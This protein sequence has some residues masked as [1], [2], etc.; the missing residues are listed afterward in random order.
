MNEVLDEAFEF[1]RDHPRNVSREDWLDFCRK[2]NIQ[3]NE[4]KVVKEILIN[5]LNNNNSIS[6]D[7]KCKKLQRIFSCDPFDQE[8]VKNLLDFYE[9]RRNCDPDNF[10][11][12]YEEI[13]I[14]YLKI[15]SN[16]NNSLSNPSPVQNVPSSNPI[17]NQNN[18]SSSSG[19]NNPNSPPKTSPYNPSSTTPD[20]SQPPNPKQPHTWYIWLK[21]LVK[22]FLEAYF[23][24]T[25]PF[26]R[27]AKAAIPP[28]N[29][30]EMGTNIKQQF[31]NKKPNF[32]KSF[33]KYKN[34]ISYIILAF[35]VFLLVLIL[36]FLSFSIYFNNIDNNAKQAG[37][38]FQ[39]SNPS[40][41]ENKVK[42]EIEA[43]EEALIAADK[44]NK[45]AQKV[46]KI[47]FF[48]SIPFLSSWL[49]YAPFET[50]NLIMGGKIHEKN[51][52]KMPQDSIQSM[53]I[54]SDDSSFDDPYIA[55][56]T[57]N[58]TVEL[59]KLSSL[60]SAKGAAYHTWNNNCDEVSSLRFDSKGERLITGGGKG[61]V[62]ILTMKQKEPQV[63]PTETEG[64]IYSVSF[65]PDDKF[66]AFAQDEKL[67]VV[68][69]KTG[70]QVGSWIPYSEGNE[71]LILDIS[72]NKKGTRI[73]TAGK[74]GIVKLWEWK[75]PDDSLK[76]NILSPFQPKSPIDSWN[77]YTYKGINDSDISFNE[78]GTG[79]VKLWKWEASDNSLRQDI[80]SPFQLKY[81]TS[82]N[83][84]EDIE[85]FEEGASLKTS[86][87][88]SGNLQV[89][90]ENQKI[91]KVLEY[92]EKGKEPINTIKLKGY[93]TGYGNNTVKG[94]DFLSKDKQLF[95]IT[96]GPLSNNKESS[97]ASFF[98][99]W[100]L[101]EKPEYPFSRDMQTK[102]ID[103]VR[104]GDKSPPNAVSLLALAKSNTLKILS[105]DGKKDVT[106]KEIKNKQ[107]KDMSFLPAGERFIT[108]DIHDNIQI[109]NRNVEKD[110]KPQHIDK[111][112]SISV[113]PNG[114]K[115]AIG[116]EVGSIYLLLNSKPDASPTL[117]RDLS[118]QIKF[119]SFSK[120]GQYLVASEGTKA[121]IFDISKSSSNDRG[122]EVNETLLSG[123][124]TGVE[125]SDNNYILIG[126]KG[127]NKIET[128][129]VGGDHY[130]SFNTDLDGGVKSF[131]L[132][133]KS[134]LFSFPSLN[135]SLIATV[136]NGDDKIIQIWTWPTGKLIARFTSKLKTVNTIVLSND[137][138]EVFLGGD[139]G[140]N[141]KIER[142]PVN[143]LEKLIKDGCTWLED[144]H[145]QYPDSKSICSKN[146]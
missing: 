101:S 84:Y 79:I 124:I 67:I 136:S 34:I 64:K 49:P 35:L 78:S 60:K 30:R 50:L 139:D 17:T 39:A 5:E 109:W 110:G 7:E 51:R 135:Q 55:I 121:K 15:L 70:T 92:S 47:P 8:T 76:Q 59:W 137:G 90:A 120:N 20:T 72:F 22:N 118:D 96:Q 112:T 82:W 104:L 56:S 41:Q 61:K 19:Q 52:F 10:S 74:N 71:K 16:Q 133:Q 38:Y 126:S 46:D 37:Q 134:L 31:A 113:D 44:L 116:T 42:Y 114:E 146:K 1:L 129:K 54:L 45:V 81:I 58:K 140:Q 132:S 26:V 63:I 9:R 83:A 102:S 122:K 25:L 87:N 3:A 108:V 11:H 117:F 65:S 127:N 2:K 13:R 89:V 69:S 107:F 73:A 62:C 88:E 111:I 18:S 141:G 131:N 119:L 24:D 40:S 94:A 36:S 48:N 66:I 123:G 143:S 103:R 32:L 142:W 106:P 138:K 93:G 91:L 6:E 43:L 105:L 85:G 97:Q 33:K 57:G 21:N 23:P 86:F 95:T 68:D 145:T 4:L 14:H 128:F 53:A 29:F 115:T 100:D 27:V 98:Q 80:L 75:V 77:D 99:Y 125:L 12:L 130:K 28:L 144:Y